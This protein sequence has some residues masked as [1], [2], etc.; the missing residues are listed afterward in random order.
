VRVA[1]ENPGL[2]RDAEE[3]RAQ[4]RVPDRHEASR[5]GGEDASTSEGSAG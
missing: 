3:L 4:G 1:P 2:L 5:P